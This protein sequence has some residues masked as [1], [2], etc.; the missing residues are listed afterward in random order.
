M[1]VFTLVTASPRVFACMLR[2]E[3]EPSTVTWP[4]QEPQLKQ[5][6]FPP[7]V[8]LWVPLWQLL[9]VLLFFFFPG[10]GSRPCHSSTRG[11]EQ[12]DKS[13]DRIEKKKPGK[14]CEDASDTSW[15]ITEGLWGTAQGTSAKPTTEYPTLP[16]SYLFSEKFIFFNRIKIW[17]EIIAFT[18]FACKRCLWKDL[19]KQAFPQTGSGT[20][21]FSG[22]L[23]G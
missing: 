10:N 17:S 5:T 13:C 12:T 14:H 21:L 3:P 2:E 9:R 19:P 1:R 16:Q 7:P 8:P 23:I 20:Q 6:H 11:L 18:G 15:G 4:C 22:T